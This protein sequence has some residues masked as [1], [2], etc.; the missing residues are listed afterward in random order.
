M[1]FIIFVTAW[2]AYCNGSVMAL[3]TYEGV[4]LVFQGQIGRANTVD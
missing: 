3:L 4:M 2:L 1:A